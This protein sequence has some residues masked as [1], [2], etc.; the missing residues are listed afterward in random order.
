MRAEMNY[1]TGEP[2]H[3]SP[4]NTPQ[5]PHKCSSRVAGLVCYLK[6]VFSVARLFFLWNN[7]FLGIQ[8][9][10]KSDKSLKKHAVFS[11]FNTNPLGN[12]G[13]SPKGQILQKCSARS[14]ISYCVLYYFS[15]LLA[16]DMRSCF[17]FTVGVFLWEIPI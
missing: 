7:A 4:L 15:V 1:P 3:F 5:V 10:R 13:A 9:E 8:S 2:N 16:Y 17:S 14:E 12:C 6:L 11:L